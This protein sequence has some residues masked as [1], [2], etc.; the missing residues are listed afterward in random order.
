MNKLTLGKVM[1]YLEKYLGKEFG[2][3]ED[4]NLTWNEISN[5]IRKI[6]KTILENQKSASCKTGKISG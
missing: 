5:I 6:A 4:S 3:Q 2:T 1:V